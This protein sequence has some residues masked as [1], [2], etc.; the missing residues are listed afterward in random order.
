MKRV[1]GRVDLY[2]R[3][4]VTRLLGVTSGLVAPAAVCLGLWTLLAGEWG[5][6]LW[7]VGAALSAWLASLCFLKREVRA[8]LV[9]EQAAPPTKPGEQRP[10]AW[11]SG[12]S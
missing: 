10:A 7:V 12:R 11:P 3:P 4:A 5:G 2:S 1:L 9:N 8:A 6:L